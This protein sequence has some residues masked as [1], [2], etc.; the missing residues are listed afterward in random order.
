MRIRKIGYF[1]SGL[2]AVFFVSAGAAQAVCPVCAVAIAGGVGLSRWV[3]IDDSITGAWIG[4]LLAALTYWTIEWLERK[5]Q[6]FAGYRWAVALF[7]I[8]IGLAPLHRYGILWHPYNKLWGA[9]KLVLG[10]VLG[11]IFFIGANYL[12][13]LARKKNNGKSYFLF[14]RVVFSVGSIVILSLVLFFINR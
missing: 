14:Q 11:G 8:L 5:K 13:Q 12:Y 2:G 6:A 1:F 7:Y 10:I 9:D 4:A 3:G